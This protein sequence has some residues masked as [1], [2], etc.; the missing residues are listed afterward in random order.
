MSPL[1]ARTPDLER[2]QELLD[3]I[4][5]YLADHGLAQATLRPMA[6]ELGVS[7]NRLVH[8]FGTKD[9]L[10]ATAIRRAVERQVAVEQRWIR[11]HPNISMADIYRKWWRWLVD[12]PEHLAL[13]RLSYEAAALDTT[14]SGLPGD[15]RADQLT[16]WRHSVE[17]RL[18][19]DGLS[20]RTAA[21]EASLQ[22]AMFTGLIIELV[23]TGE[24]RRLTRTLEANLA[25]LEQF[26]DEHRDVSASAAE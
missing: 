9:E 8:H 14:V 17:E 1:V 2:R 23:A 16:V 18:R 6:A 5:A 11:R 19:R 3:R 22:K 26:I 20:A 25:R 15:L 10:I 7:I 12:D 13:V 4:V 24:R 21:L